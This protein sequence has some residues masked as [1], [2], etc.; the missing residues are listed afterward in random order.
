MTTH[1]ML[2]LGGRIGTAVV[3]LKTV[4]LSTAP[5]QTTDTS[6]RDKKVRRILH[7]I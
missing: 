5:M 6:T 7:R 3:K 1:S 4:R 2:A